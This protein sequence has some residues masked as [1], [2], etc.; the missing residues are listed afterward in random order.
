MQIPLPRTLTDDAFASACAHLCGDETDLS[1]GETGRKIAELWNA[2]SPKDKQEVPFSFRAPS[3]LLPPLSSLLLVCRVEKLVQEEE[4]GRG[5]RTACGA[6]DARVAWQFEKQ[7]VVLREK[8]LVEKSKYEASNPTAPPPPVAK[9]K[10]KDKEGK[11]RP[12]RILC[13]P[14]LVARL[15]AVRR[16]VVWCGMV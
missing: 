8:F 4:E 13:S 3:L 7:A 15:L 10:G 5:Q 11:V 12:A 16:R 6:E 9:S 14:L 1:F 2:K